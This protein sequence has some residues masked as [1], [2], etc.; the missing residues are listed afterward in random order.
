MARKL[1]ETMEEA[2][3][4]L[5][6]H[7]GEEGRAWLRSIP[8]S[9][10]DDETWS[11]GAGM[12]KEWGLWDESCQLMFAGEWNEDYTEW[13]GPHPDDVSAEIIERAWRE[14]RSI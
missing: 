6:D 5:L 14:V 4:M 11:L 1:P 3:R 2:V 7:L 8:E 10:L 13:T 9:D 12:R